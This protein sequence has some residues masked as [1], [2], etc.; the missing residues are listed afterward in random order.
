MTLYKR[1]QATDPNNPS[2]APAFVPATPEDV[3]EAFAEINAP[4]IA[5]ADDTSGGAGEAIS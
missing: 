5:P 1:V 4:T 3:R 2:L